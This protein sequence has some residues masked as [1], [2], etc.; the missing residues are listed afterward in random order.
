MGG[1]RRGTKI[2]TQVPHIRS[3]GSWVSHPKAETSE[4]RPPPQSRPTL[5]SSARP[6]APAV[7]NIQALHVPE[8]GTE[9]LC[10]LDWKSPPI[11]QSQGSMLARLPPLTVK[12]GGCA[13]EPHT[14]VSV[15][16]SWAG[17]RRERGG[18][19]DNCNRITIKCF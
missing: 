8:D 2:P 10:C 19:W 11:L 9:M 6:K 16:G 13:V 18:N 14:V 15:H 1:T 5:T 17:Q 7:S 4:H 3:R 12:I